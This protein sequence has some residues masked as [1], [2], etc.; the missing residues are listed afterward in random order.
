MTTIG[1]WFGVHE[2]TLHAWQYDKYKKQ[3]ND[4]AGEK[5]ICPFNQQYPSDFSCTS[6]KENGGLFLGPPGFR[7]IKFPSTYITVDLND[8]T[9]VSLDGLLVVF[10]ATFQYQIREADI[11][12][13]ITKYRNFE[14]WADI[15]EQAGERAPGAA[16]T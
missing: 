1:V 6:P 14:K 13:A 5:K 11:V 2:L 12:E 4:A 7:F 8:R 9:C 3:L 10:S 15:V 16:S